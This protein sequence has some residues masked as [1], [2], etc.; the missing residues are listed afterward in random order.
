MADI[1]SESLMHVVFIYLN[2]FLHNIRVLA[3]PLLVIT[4][5]IY[6]YKYFVQ[7]KIRRV[8]SEIV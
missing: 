7:Q 8:Y 3:V 1:G 4:I 2:I 5:N 6:F